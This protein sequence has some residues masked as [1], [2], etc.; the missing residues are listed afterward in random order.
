MHRRYTRLVLDLARP[1]VVTGIPNVEA[2][3]TEQC[4]MSNVAAN[5][6][7]FSV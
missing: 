6:V 4:S 2:E 3:S 7:P 5:G 1:R